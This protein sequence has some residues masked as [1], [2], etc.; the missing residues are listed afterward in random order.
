MQVQKKGNAAGLM[1]YLKAQASQALDQF[2]LFVLVLVV[3]RCVRYVLQSNKNKHLVL[4]QPDHLPYPPAWSFCLVQCTSNQ[5]NKQ[6]TQTQAPT[7]HCTKHPHLLGKP[8][9]SQSLLP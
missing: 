4:D 1:A 8:F 3:G 5:A 7:I 9:L 6:S 2:D